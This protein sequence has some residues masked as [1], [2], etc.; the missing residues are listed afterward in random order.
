MQAV[1]ESWLQLVVHVNFAGSHMQPL[2]AEQAPCVV[3]D[4][5]QT[6][7]QVFVASL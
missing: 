3:Y 1:L 4:A 2:A 6:P 7:P 5:A